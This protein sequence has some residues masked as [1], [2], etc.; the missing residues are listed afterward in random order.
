[1]VTTG[2]CGEMADRGSFARHQKLHS[3]RFLDDCQWSQ[4]EIGLASPFGQ[5]SNVILFCDRK[6]V[7]HQLAHPGAGA[8]IGSG[9]SR[10]TV[11]QAIF[12]EL[13]ASQFG[14]SF[15][16]CRDL[17]SGRRTDEFVPALDL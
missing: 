1:M 7:T 15:L 6:R 5:R 13:N 3:S 10:E 8:A 17:R 12:I 4:S 16:S 2:C 11:P 9:I 14:E